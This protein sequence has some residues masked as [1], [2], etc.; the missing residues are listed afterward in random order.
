METRTSSGLL[1]LSL[2]VSLTL[3]SVAKVAKAVSLRRGGV[4]GCGG[5]SGPAAEEAGLRRLVTPRAPCI[6][7]QLRTTSTRPVG[8]RNG[9]SLCFLNSVLQGMSSLPSVMSYLDAVVGAKAVAEAA[10]GE[11]ATRQLLS[12]LLRECLRGL[13]GEE[14]VRGERR[15]LGRGGR[16]NTTL[17]E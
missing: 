10:G 1:G 16:R 3:Y 15:G 14:E 13:S 17:H 8:L 9:A 7:P 6:P 4:A 11:A 12:E 5:G 2:L